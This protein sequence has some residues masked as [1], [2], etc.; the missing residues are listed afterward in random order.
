[1]ANKSLF[2]S[3]VG[4][5]ILKT[6]A[7]NHEFAP[8]YALSPKAM[9]AQYAAT[10]CMGSTFYASADEQ[11]AAVL[12]LCRTMQPEF[13]ARC[14]LYARRDGYMKDVPA[15][16]CAVLSVRSPGLLAEVFDRVID[17]A[18][19]LRNFVQMIRSGVVGRKSLGTLP[20]RLVLQWLESRSDDQLFRGSVGNDPSLVDI[21]KMV[22]PKPQSVSREALYAYL[23][24]RDYQ[25]DRLPELVRQ[26][27]AFKRGETNVVPD[28]PFQLL[29]SLNLTKRHWQD[30][31]R[32]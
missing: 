3:I 18:R 20:K 8:A 5:L 9:L 4:K 16:L 27:E 32:R 15:L 13:I 22:H 28:V 17:D 12:E 7:L 25:M 21:I 31:A 6:D 2:K 10:G 1:M 30:I 29:T 24:G 11:L 23:I 26:Y 19:M 14:A